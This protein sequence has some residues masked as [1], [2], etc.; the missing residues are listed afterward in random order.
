MEINRVYNED[1]LDTIAR[2]PDE[3]IDLIVTSPPYNLDNAKKGSFY[4]GK[5]K[6]ENISYDN[7]NDNLPE[8]EYIDWQHDLFREWMRLIKPTGAIFYNHKPRIIEGIYDDRKN[9][10]PFK[11]RQE[12]VWD[13]CGMVN[14][15]GSFYANNTERIYII[16]KDNWKPVRKYLGWGEV[17]RFSPEQNTKHPAPFPL[18]LI[19]RIIISAT[20]KG[21]LVYDPMLGSG[22]VAIACIKENRQWIGSEISAEYCKIANKRIKAEQ[23]KIDLFK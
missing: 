17:W 3:S 4:G 6:G 11:I 14:F 23:Q 7:H 1:C 2:M 8:Q 13:R 21:D 22:T 9:L 19:N 12:I 5:S 10:I 20:N 16:C 18:K 15:S